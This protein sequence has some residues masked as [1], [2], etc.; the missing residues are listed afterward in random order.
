MLA[1]LFQQKHAM[2]TSRNRK[3]HSKEPAPLK[4]PASGDL[5][6]AFRKLVKI[7]LRF[8]GVEESRSYGTPALKVKGKFLARLRTEAEGGLAIHCEL[9]EREMLMQAEPGVFY[10]TDH[11]KDS[12]M[13]LINLNKVRWDA[14]PY[15][16][17]QAWRTVASPKL[18]K[19][20]DSGA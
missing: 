8:P 6:K 7:A 9:V 2:P 19:E 10:I 1:V 12:A 13:I 20:F 16:V 3:P 18:L 11:Y 14:M 15:F 4:F 5:A 17:E